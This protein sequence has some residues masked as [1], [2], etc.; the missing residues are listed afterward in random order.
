MVQKPPAEVICEQLSKAKL[1]KFESLPHIHAMG[2]AIAAI[3]LSGF[4]LGNSVE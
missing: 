3:W 1:T 2:P 4:I